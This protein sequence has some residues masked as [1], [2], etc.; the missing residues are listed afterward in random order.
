[1]IVAL[2]LPCRVNQKDNY[3]KHLF[4]MYYLMISE[5]KHGVEMSPEITTN[6]DA[7][8][9]E[10]DDKDSQE[11]LPVGG[12][13]MLGEQERFTYESAYCLLCSSELEVQFYNNH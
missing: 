1:M 3:I 12:E 8:Q 6:G 4:N 7:G 2:R 10:T 5:Q 9:V 11:L 13:S